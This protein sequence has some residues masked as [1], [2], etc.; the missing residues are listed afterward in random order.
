M[1]RRLDVRAVILGSRPLGE[2]DRIVILLT[3]EAGHIHAVVKGVRKTRSRWGGRLEPFNVCD[4]E[5]VRGRSLA[6]VTGADVVAAFPRLRMDRDG[7]AAAAVVCETAARLFPEEEPHERA[8]GL[9]CR[10]LKMIDEGFVGPALEAPLVLGAVVKLLHEAGF[11]PVLEHCACCGGGGEAAAFSA[12]RGG[13][14]CRDCAGEGVSIGPAS[15]SALCDAVREPLAVLRER[16]P[17]AAVDE[18]LRHLHG[19]VVHHS[20]ARLRSLR[21]AGR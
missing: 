15:V 18:A 14:V 17:S 7:L 6:T 10:A 1:S 19:L 11:L 8:F 3:R 9:T 21:D 12:A 5:L 2:A 4:L 20:G 13:L 16:P